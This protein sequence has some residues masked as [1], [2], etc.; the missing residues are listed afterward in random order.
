MANESIASFAP[1]GFNIGTYHPRVICPNIKS[2]ILP[3]LR[4]GGKRPGFANPW[5]AN[6]YV[7]INAEMY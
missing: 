6:N 2:P 3:N 1:R 7:P 4:F 5:R